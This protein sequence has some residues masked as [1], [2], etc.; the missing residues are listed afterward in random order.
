MN[1]L[2][3]TTVID[4]TAAL[5]RRGA[6]AAAAPP[7]TAVVRNSR[8][9]LMRPPPRVADGMR[10]GSLL[11]RQGDWARA[12]RCARTGRFEIGH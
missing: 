1:E 8:R 3:W 12:A 10:G 11:A 7:T 4:L 5:V 2:S 9:V 6:R